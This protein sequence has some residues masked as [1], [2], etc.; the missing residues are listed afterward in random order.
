M[1]PQ[2]QVID[3]SVAGVSTTACSAQYD[4]VITVAT[5]Q[6]ARLA[7][8]GSLC[9]ASGYDVKDNMIDDTRESIALGMPCLIAGIGELAAYLGLNESGQH[10]AKVLHTQE[11]VSCSWDRVLPLPTRSAR[12]GDWALVVDVG[13]G[14]L[15][16]R[17]GLCLEA[18]EET[19][20]LD[21][22]MVTFPADSLE[23]PPEIQVLP[24]AKLVALPSRPQEILTPRE[25]EL[26]H[27]SL[28]VPVLHK[29]DPELVGSDSESSASCT[30][31]SEEEEVPQKRLRRDSGCVGLGDINTQ[32]ETMADI[33]AK[34]ET[35]ARQVNA[36]AMPEQGST[37]MLDSG[38]P[39]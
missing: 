14:H 20:V 37:R 21:P 23:V 7:R 9:A 38:P 27:T 28:S 36:E 18:L 4:R 32:T 5:L 33:K 8:H 12:P 16:G 19:S 30:C 6:A 3:T 1:V 2:S 26:T 13:E 34:A 25:A 10:Q 15:T 17:L 31:S 29:A 22:V 11:V 35:S 24:R 39:S